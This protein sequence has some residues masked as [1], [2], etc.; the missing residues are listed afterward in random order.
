MISGWTSFVIVISFNNKKILQV[1]VVLFTLKA[2]SEKKVLSFLRE[3]IDNKYEIYKYLYFIFLSAN[4]IKYQSKT[5]YFD[6]YIY[7]QTVNHNNNLKA[8]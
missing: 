3:K 2:L 1:K 5:W 8:L 4:L 7:K 6:R